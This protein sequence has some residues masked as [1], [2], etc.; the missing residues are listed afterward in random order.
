MEI[1]EVTWPKGIGV[2]DGIK[3]P[4]QLSLRYDNYPRLPRGAQCNHHHP[5][6]SKRKAEGAL[7][8]QNSER[9]NM[10][11]FEDEDGD[12]KS[13][14]VGNFEKCEKIKMLIRC[15]RNILLLIHFYW[16]N[17]TL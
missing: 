13:R 17:E 2:T 1:Y 16:S 11:G 3:V 14:N 10:V 6:K 9:C 12:N 5:Q 4:S 8:P 15:A 7:T